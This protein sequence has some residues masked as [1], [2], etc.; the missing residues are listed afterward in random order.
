[1]PG[2]KEKA[3]LKS[4]ACL[5]CG[6]EIQP[7]KRKFCCRSHKD[8][9]NHKNLYNYKYHKKMRSKSPRSFMS[10]LRS[11]YNRK[12]SLSLDFLENMYSKQKGLCA[13]SGEEMTHILDNGKYPTNISIDRIDSSLGYSEDNVQLVC[14][15]VNLMKTDGTLEELIDWCDKIH[16][17]HINNYFD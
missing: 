16:M 9:Y 5:H 8:S 11:Y 15:R 10:Q 1:M 7:P 12:E 3:V 17:Y 2:L 4:R 6:E 13:I 14:H